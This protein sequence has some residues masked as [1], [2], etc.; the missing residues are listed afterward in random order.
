MIICIKCW[1]AEPFYALAEGWDYNPF[2]V[3]GGR[4]NMCQLFGKDMQTFFFELNE[5]LAA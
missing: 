4:G 3:H 2:D 5:A 1:E